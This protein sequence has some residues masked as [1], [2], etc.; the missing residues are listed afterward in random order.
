MNSWSLLFQ[1][2]FGHGLQLLFGILLYKLH[3]GVFVEYSE[4]TLA[5]QYLSYLYLGL[6]YAVNFY[7]S[8]EK[9]KFDKSDL[10][11]NASSLVLILSLLPV[12]IS[13]IFNLIYLNADLLKSL[14][15]SSSIVSLNI[16]VYVYNIWRSTDFIYK[17]NYSTILL[18]GTLLI[19]SI[20]TND[21]LIY[22]TIITLHGIFIFLLNYFFY[23]KMSLEFK[24]FKLLIKKGFALLIY[25][26]SYYL[27]I[28]SLRTIIR[29]RA[30]DNIFADISLGQTLSNSVFLLLGTL[31]WIFYSKIL[32]FFSSGYKEHRINKFINDISIKYYSSVELIV[33]FSITLLISIN[34]FDLIS[35]NLAFIMFVLLLSNLSLHSIFPIGEYLVAINK[36]NIL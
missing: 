9:E 33:Y 29:I 19:T 8:T 35:E 6:P 24:Y 34:Y 10:I 1:K 18:F 11:N 15:I 36:Q 32:K 2:I 31:S 17:V 26:V 27:F 25:N 12:L 3:K 23:N 20:I 30:D 22:L 28:Q 13:L 21:Y 7:L 16:S 4:L 14:L 5:N